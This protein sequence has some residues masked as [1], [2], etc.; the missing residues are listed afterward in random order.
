LHW[1]LGLAEGFDPVGF[2]QQLGDRIRFVHLRNTIREGPNDRARHSFT[3]SEHLAGNTDMEA[4]VRALMDEEKRRRD[5]G[6]QDHSIAMRPDHGH[7][8]LSDMTQPTQ[9]G[10]HLIGRMRG[11]AELRGVILASSQD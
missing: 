8:L 2:I 7:A 4:T 6:R 3:E 5:M 10:C 1:F 11:L 9:P